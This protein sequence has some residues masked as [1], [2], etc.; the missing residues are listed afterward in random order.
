MKAT[1]RVSA[2]SLALSLGLVTTAFAEPPA[3][4]PSATSPDARAAQMLA[5]MTLDEKISL[6]HGEFP[7]LMRSLPPGVSISAGYVPGAPRLGIPS[8]R[9]SDASLGVANAG[10][11]ND[12]AVALPSGMALAA[13]WNPAIA[14]SGGAMIGKETRQKGFNVLLAGGVNLTRDPFN[15]RNFEYLGEDPLLAGTLAGASIQ[16]IQSQH[17]VSTTKHFVLNAQETGR[18]VADARIGE[19]ALRESD[20]LAFELAIEKGRPGSVMCS[21]NKINGP[22]AC[23]ARHTLTDILKTDWG[24][25]GWVM[26][27]WG[28]VHSVD[29]AVAGLDQESGQQLDKQV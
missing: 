13:T 4:A 2:S 20:L 19:A 27:D 8:L 15:G 11:E 22:Y 5:R 24:W 18:H 26:S 23:E 29:A 6:L 14:A 12:D 3:P 1:M 28:A 7:R 16:G 17:V 9:E 25:K 10:R 21:Y